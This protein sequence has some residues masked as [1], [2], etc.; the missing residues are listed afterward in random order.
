[1]TK[2]PR[3]GVYHVTVTSIGND[4]FSA[5]FKR[6]ERTNPAEIAINLVN[7]CAEQML[8]FMHDD[9]PEDDHKKRDFFMAVGMVLMTMA[10][11]MDKCLYRPLKSTLAHWQEALNDWEQDEKKFDAKKADLSIKTENIVE[12]YK[13]FALELKA[14]W[15]ML[16]KL[17]EKTTNEITDDVK[18]EMHD[19]MQETVKEI[20]EKLKVKSS[21][22]AE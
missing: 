16:V 8:G 19:L 3:E 2:K 12:A 18:K 1:M 15:E 10:H 9:D 17:H 6:I 7:I 11:P 21:G 22:E 4:F 14:L 5:G 13:D 20:T